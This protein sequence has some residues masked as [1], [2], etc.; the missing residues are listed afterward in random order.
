MKSKFSGHLENSIS[1]AVLKN[2]NLA[3][4]SIDNTIKIWDTISGLLKV[5]LTGH[6]GDIESLVVLPNGNLASASHDGT[7][8]IWQLL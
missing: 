1:L 6:S 8:K 2:G 5:T 7:I 4:G 3:S